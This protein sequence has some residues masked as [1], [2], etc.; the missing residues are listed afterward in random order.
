MG[1][2]DR[3]FKPREVEDRGV[4][5]TYFKMI[6]SYSPVFTDYKGGVYE[7]AL[8][9]A[10]IDTFAKHVSKANA[11]IKG[12]VY[13]SLQNVLN[14]RPN[15]IMV[16]TQFLS[17]LAI[18]YKSENNAFIIPQYEDR[19]AARIIGFYPVRASDTKIHTV[20]GELMLTYTIHDT[21]PKKYS[22][23]YNE[24]GH[25]RKSFYRK[26]LYGESNAPI[27]A[28]MDL[29]TTQDQA[30]KNSVKQSATIRFMAKLA[31]ILRPEDVKIEQ[32]RLRNINLSTDNNGGIF[33]YD[34]K[35]A[36]I[37]QVESKPFTVDAEQM[38]LINESVYNYFGTNQ[39][40]LQNTASES[41]WEAYY[42]GELEPFLIELSQV[43]TNMIFNISE[44]NKGSML[45]WESS[46][47]QYASSATK[48][49]LITQLFDRGFITH[50][51]GRRI[52]NMP[53]REDGDKFYIRREYA[54]VNKL[55][56]VEL[57]EQEVEDDNE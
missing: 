20:N 37:K 8:T 53:E 55:E 3:F 52:F 36:E 1:V 40:I 30:I 25:L 56:E 51:D 31:S 39:R 10:S 42:E 29:L 57:I 28:T 2:F 22:I 49:S 14:Y 6:T 38:K 43:M 24:V 27:T 4:V 17:K 33:V 48:L 15:E 26:E 16:T 13:Q 54:E 45:I 7:M 12:D 23:P 21:T 34:N 46:R 32:E 47:L 19:T 35:Y 11:V 9:R 5:D 41:E 44:I 50:N 18:I